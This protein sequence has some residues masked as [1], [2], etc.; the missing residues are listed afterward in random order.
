MMLS[1]AVDRE[2]VDA[3]YIRLLQLRLSR[4]AKR[5][6]RRRR[7]AL[8]ISAARLFLQ[9]GYDS[10][11]AADIARA[12]GLS[13][14]GFYV[15]FESKSHV[16]VSVLRPFFVLTFP[17]RQEILE[18]GPEACLQR[19]YARIYA[20]RRLVQAIEPLRREAPDFARQLDARILRWH[21]TLLKAAG[22]DAA[23]ARLLS[24]TSLGVAWLPPV[25]GATLVPQTGAMTSSDL[26]L[27]RAS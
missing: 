8:R 2:C 12:A 25:P 1:P 9:H 20:H 26:P 6:G 24:A 4:A 23:Q 21:E 19:L 22:A 15:Y 14:A 16:A 10:V 17:L 27:R 3:P 11:G 7:A 18:V 5:K 13:K